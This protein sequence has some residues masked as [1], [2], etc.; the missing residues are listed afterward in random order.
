M[1]ESPLSRIR[2][3][4]TREEAIR[5]LVESLS[6]VREGDV[7]EELTPCFDGFGEESTHDTDEL[8]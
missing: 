2:H 4:K 8:E 5:I 6:C 7:E 1:P 3:V